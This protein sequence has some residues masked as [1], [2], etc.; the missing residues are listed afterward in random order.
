MST[1]TVLWIFFR[2]RPR[3]AEV[4]KAIIDIE[5]RTRDEYEYEDDLDRPVL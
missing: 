1:R 4:R 2:R 5:P 3:K